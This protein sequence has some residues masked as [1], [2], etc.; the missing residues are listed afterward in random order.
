MGG[1]ER[2]ERWVEEGQ[3]NGGRLIVSK[4]HVYKVL[5]EHV[6]QQQQLWPPNSSC[7]MCLHEPVLSDLLTRRSLYNIGT[8]QVTNH[9]AHL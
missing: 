6:C 1:W 2:W 9:A 5:A 4:T 7:S 3:D 8:N